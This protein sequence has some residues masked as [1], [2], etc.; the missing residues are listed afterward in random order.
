MYLQKLWFVAN[1][2][3]NIA[4]ISIRGTKEYQAAVGW[5]N[6]FYKTER[7]NHSFHH[8]ARSLVLQSDWFNFHDIDISMKMD[9][10]RSGIPH[11]LSELIKTETLRPASHLSPV[12]ITKETQPH[13]QINP[14]ERKMFSRPTLLREI[15]HHST[16][17]EKLALSVGCRMNFQF[18]VGVGLN[19]SR[20]CQMT[21]VPPSL[22]NHWRMITNGVN[23]R[24]DQQ[25]H[26]IGNLCFQSFPVTHSWH[27]LT[28]ALIPRF[29]ANNSFPYCFTFP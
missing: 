22:E 27:V 8:K 11:V 1:T 16:F 10:C 3:S 15:K 23:Q 26:L 9:V 28:E 2:I 20:L 17:G 4:C 25:S 13:L 7:T 14:L 5:A 12:G 29:L 18:Y 21:R 19:E 6:S 24:Q